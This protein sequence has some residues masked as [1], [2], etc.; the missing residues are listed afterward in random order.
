[1][2]SLII[3]GT[4]QPFQC[5]GLRP[6][7]CQRAAS[8]QVDSPINTSHQHCQD[9]PCDLK[10]AVN[11]CPIGSQ[12]CNLLTASA[13]TT[14]EIK[15]L[16][17]L[18]WTSSRAWPVT[19]TSHQVLATSRSTPR[20]TTRALG[21]LAGI[22]TGGLHAVTYNPDYAF[23]GLFAVSRS[24]RQRDRTTTWN[25]AGSTGRGDLHRA[26]SRTNDGRRL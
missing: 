12:P 24:P 11:R 9:S 10:P 15:A 3:E 26:R 20:R 21:G 19:K 5:P 18:I 13:M 1:M 17:V 4:H 16:Q 22:G 6:A 7:A 8:T 14:V 25:H 2:G 23:I